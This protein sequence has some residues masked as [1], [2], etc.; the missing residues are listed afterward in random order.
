MVDG[1]TEA[2]LIGGLVAFLAA[3]YAA[4]FGWLVTGIH[5]LRRDMQTLNRETRLELGARIEAV[6]Q[7]IGARID[8]LDQRLS[9]KIDGLA[10][11]VSRLKGAGQNLD[12][13]PSNPTN[14]QKHDPNGCIN[15][16][17]S[18]HQAPAKADLLANE[19]LS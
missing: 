1:F 7:K 14:P 19:N 11:A 5:T 17:Q 9:A 15:Q 4:F 2:Q 16:R 13:Q 8:T 18:N 3:S 6:D 10:I 12:I